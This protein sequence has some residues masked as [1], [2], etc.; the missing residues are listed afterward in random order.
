MSVKEQG[1]QQSQKLQHDMDVNT[2]V[3][4]LQMHTS[5]VGKAKRHE[6]GKAM[7]N[8]DL[9]ET[10]ATFAAQMRCGADPASSPFA[11]EGTVFRVPG[12]E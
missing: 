7:N 1:C 12:I 5:F 4:L 3:K 8:L 9:K 11:L 6:K 10:V 2:V